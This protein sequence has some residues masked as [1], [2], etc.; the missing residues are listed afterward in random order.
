LGIQ[1]VT[2]FRVAS[3]AES[4]DRVEVT[5]GS[6]EKAGGFTEQ[7]RREFQRSRAQESRTVEIFTRGKLR[8]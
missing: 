5:S 8:F 3:V 4:A 6:G 2:G 1:V 7:G